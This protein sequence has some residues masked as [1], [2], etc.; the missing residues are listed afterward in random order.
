MTLKI[1]LVIGITL[2]VFLIASYFYTLIYTKQEKMPT[3]IH[4]KPITFIP[5][6]DSFTIG[7]G[8]EELDRWPNIMVENFAK[9]NIQI[10]ILDNPAVSGFTVRDVINFQL[11][12]LEKK[13]PDFITIFIGTND[14]FMQTDVS[15]F[16]RE[17][18]ELLDKVQK[19]LPNSTNIV[20]I[21]IPDYSKFPGMVAYRGSDLEDFIA[22][23]NQVIVEEAKRRGLV[24]ADIFSISHTMTD[25]ND[26]IF[27]GVHPTRSGY[28]KFESEI[29]PKVEEVL[30]R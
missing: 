19:L 20:L 26:F 17:Y 8:V 16:A 23:Y 11:P 1:F 18:S 9:E 27:D 5:L 2:F 13:K 12:L 30:L 7:L 10:K 25:A 6:G 28:I 4:T 29:F 21:T 3:N 14:S 22:T 24:V 15:I